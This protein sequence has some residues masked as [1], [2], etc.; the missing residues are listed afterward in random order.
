MEGRFIDIKIINWTNNI[1]VITRQTNIYSTIDV[2]ILIYLWEK[3]AL[4]VMHLIV[5]EQV[6]CLVRFL[7]EGE[8][9]GT[10]IDISYTQ[11]F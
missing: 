5:K 10:K 1:Q 6:Q 9:L 4:K 7:L 2:A 8:S 3:T 11:N